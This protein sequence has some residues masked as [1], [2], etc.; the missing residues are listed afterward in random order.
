VAP[1]A[2]RQG[3]RGRE[4]AYDIAEILELSV[5]P[6]ATARKDGDTEVPAGVL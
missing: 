6:L 5:L 1:L 4:G 3:E 2:P